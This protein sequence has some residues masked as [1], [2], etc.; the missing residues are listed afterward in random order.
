MIK[1]II[2]ICLFLAFTPFLPTIANEDPYEDINNHLINYLSATSLNLKWDTTCSGNENFYFKK[3]NNEEINETEANCYEKP[4]SSER[5]CQIVLSNL[6]SNTAYDYATRCG[7]NS[8]QYTDY[9]T[10]LGQV[11]DNLFSVSNITN[12][13]ATIS[14]QTAGD[15]GSKVFYYPANNHFDQ[16]TIIKD[17]KKQN[18]EIVIPNLLS[19]T[20]YKYRV[21]S[22]SQD[23]GIISNDLYFTTLDSPIDLSVVGISVLKKRISDDGTNQIRVTVKNVGIESVNPNTGLTLVYG[24]NFT[25]IKGCGVN[26]CLG[27]GNVYNAK[28]NINAFGKNSLA[29]GEEYTILFNTSN[30]LLDTIEFEDDIEYLFKA[31]IDTENGFEDNNLVNNVSSV[32]GTPTYFPQGTGGLPDLTVTDIEFVS[33]NNLENE[34]GMLSVSIKNLGDSLTSSE[35]LLN[36]YNNFAAQNFEFDN[37][38]PSIMA[39]KADRAMPT[40]SDPMETNETI[41]FSWTGKFSTSGNLY[42]QFT[43]D[44]ANELTESNE[45][46]NTLTRA[47]SIGNRQQPD[48]T[49]DNVF[50][51]NGSNENMLLSGTPKVGEKFYLWLTY[52]NIGAIKTD[53]TDFNIDVYIDDVYSKKLKASNNEYLSDLGSSIYIDDKL[54]LALEEGSHKIKFV[55]DSDNNIAESN[56]NNNVYIKEMSIESVKIG[57]NDDNSNSNNTSQLVLQLQ[58]QI[59]A[60]EKQV[61]TLEKNLTRLDQKFAN[62][63]SGTMFLDVENHGRLW[64]VDPVSK[65]RFYFENGQSALSIGSKLATGITNEDI[66]KIPVGVPNKLYNLKDSDGDGLPDKLESALGSNLN[67]GDTDGDGLNDKEE[68]SNGYNPVNNEK[69]SFNQ[70]LTDRLEGKMLLQVSG[71]NSHGEIW[72]VKDGYRW[73]GGT[74]DSMYEIMKARSL[75]A[76]ATNIRKI[77]VGDVLGVE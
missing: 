72:Y 59:S 33:P 18:H 54:E 56:E 62:K 53:N 73:Y 64:Y 52:K 21:T 9:F 39:F 14:W 3:I 26:N 7:Q 1:K 77:E 35:G 13:S 38:N 17:T 63:Y 8:Y 51:R 70:S 67:S 42:T 24:T 44:N 34:T 47:I 43:V 41:I 15:L 30:Y 46:N 29:P 11:S 40:I 68:L 75:G 16:N 4:F 74:E 71:P 19:N 37:S 76:T 23:G 58:R 32:V 45:D 57:N 27:I 10:T 61:I 65:N 6:E 20:N 31:V 48:I 50:I 28:I 5:E 49:A 25:E 55:L 2:A 69:Y 60:L 36:W 66:Q 12:N 22:S